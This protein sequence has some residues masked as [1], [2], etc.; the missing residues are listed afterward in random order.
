MIGG[1]SGLPLPWDDLAEEIRVVVVLAFCKD[2]L[3]RFFET[4][5]EIT[6]WIFQIVD[7]F[8][9]KFAFVN[10]HFICCPKE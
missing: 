1:F 9:V 8:F 2:F 10:C 5:R 7:I 4:L 3:K 6:V